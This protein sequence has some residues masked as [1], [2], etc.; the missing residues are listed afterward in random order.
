MKQIAQGAL[1]NLDVA[2]A[3]MRS[4]EEGNPRRTLSEETQVLQTAQLPY[5]LAIEARKQL[6]KEIRSRGPG[7]VLL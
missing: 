3:H 2:E 6:Q 4:L 1:E 5:Q 7:A